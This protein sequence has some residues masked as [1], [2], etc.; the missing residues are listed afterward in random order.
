MIRLTSGTPVIIINFKQTE[1]FF[2][3]MGVVSENKKPRVSA[4][5]L[6]HYLFHDFFMQVGV[7]TCRLSDK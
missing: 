6:L 5:L 4:N 2:F 3:N 1:I 7:I